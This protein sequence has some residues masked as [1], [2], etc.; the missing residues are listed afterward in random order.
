LF[1]IQ[2]INNLEVIKCK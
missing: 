1:Y 2:D